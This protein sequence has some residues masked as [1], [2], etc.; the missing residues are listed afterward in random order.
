M[1]IFRKIYYALPPTLRFYARR[2][3]YFPLDLYTLITKGSDEMIPPR[4]KI[5]IGS[6]DFKK[7]GEHILDL[8]VRYTKLKPDGKILDI[9]CGIGRLAIPMTKYLSDKGVYEGF[10]IVK[11]GIDWCTAKISS[12]YPNF[13]FLHIDLKNDLYNLKTSNEA[14]DFEFPYQHNYFD[15]IV[16]T[17]V[18]TH[19]MPNDVKHYL[20]QISLVMKDGGYCLATFFVIN[21]E[22]LD[23]I[24][25]KKVYFSFDH[26]YD[27]YYLLDDKVKEANIAYDM[28][29]LYSMLEE[30]GLC[31]DFMSKG[32]WSNGTDSLDFQD[33]LILKKISA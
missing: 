11:M 8:V 9:G 14:K 13:H 16:L 2:I 6:G 32:S 17:S 3:V 4:G 26:K 12:R 10:D 19:M 30:C 7:Q 5:F 25:N 24:K 1:N 18:F 29:F 23:A 20:K 27:G 31:V 15:S 21:D 33:V 22:V 28:S